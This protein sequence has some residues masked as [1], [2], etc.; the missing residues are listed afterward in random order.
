MSRFG[1][2]RWSLI[3][4]AAGSSPMARRA[5]DELC[6]KEYDRQRSDFKEYLLSTGRSGDVRFG[7][8]VNTRSETI[9]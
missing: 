1:T 3:H 4:G 7:F 5:L 2:T 9:G 8:P 6:A